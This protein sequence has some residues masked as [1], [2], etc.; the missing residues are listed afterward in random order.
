M[1]PIPEYELPV[2]MYHRV[3]LDKSEA[4]KHNIYVTL[5]NLRK[6]FDL[7]KKSNYQT[8]TFQD[9][10][11]SNNSCDLNKKIILTFDD[12]YVDNYTHLFPLLKEYGFTAV[13]FL[14]TRLQRNEW[15][16]KEGEPVINMM[17][18]SQIREMAEYGVEFGGH[19]QHHVTL[20]QISDLECEQEI[21][22]CKE[23]VE[24]ITN[25]EVI[26]LSYPFGACN[27]SVKNIT[28][29]AGFKY[30][31]STN[32]GPDNFINDLFQIKRIE[33]SC[34]TRMFRFRKKVSGQYFASSFFNFKP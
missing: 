19:T 14:V 15:G 33:V 16:I 8:I 3:V 6:Q 22:G 2:L 1:K 25:N 5:A 17:N 20:S 27:E 10:D 7:L 4:G 13:I 23:D 21:M 12:G 30:G 32:T 29:K 28:K 18:S 24:K 31:I 11:A 34:K 26:S 9:L